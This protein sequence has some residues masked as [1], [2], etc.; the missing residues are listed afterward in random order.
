MAAHRLHE[1]LRRLRRRLLTLAAATGLGWGIACL[2][3]LLI[4]SIWLDLVAELPPPARIITS[5]VSLAAGL[6]I[7]VGILIAA[8]R[9]GGFARLARRLD[10]VG[11]ASG[12]IVAGFDLSGQQPIATSPLTAGLAQLAVDRAGEAAARVSPS[13]AAPARSAQRAWVVSASSALA[14]VLVCLT[15]PRLAGTEWLRFSD[16]FGDHPPFSRTV[17]RVEPGDTRV[18]YADGLDVLVSAEG[19]L[20]DRVDLVLVGDGGEETL[21]M[22]PESEGQWKAQL[23]E[24]VAPC[25]YYARAR[26]ARSHQYGIDVITVPRL[27]T[28]RWRIAPPAY[29]GD[30]A[31]EGPTPSGGLAGLPGTQVRVWA[32]SNRPLLAGS[33]VLDANGSQRQIE[34]APL[35]AGSREVA[36]QFTIESAGKFSLRVTDVAGQDSQEQFSGTITLLSDHRPLVRLLEP[37]EQSLATPTATLPVVVAA[38]DDYGISRLQLYRSLN[39]SRALPL[40]FEVQAVRRSRDSAETAAPRRVQQATFLPLSAYELEPGDVIK[41]YA[42]VEDNDPAGA[43]GAESAVATVQIIAADD[44]SRMLRAREGMDVFLSKYQEALRRM[45][46]LGS[47]AEGLRK[48][49]KESPEDS[50]LADEDRRRL[51]ELSQK[52][53]EAA[54]AVRESAAELLPYDL[55]KAL[56]GELERVA[57]QLERAGQEMRSAAG[58]PG[59]KAGDL[60]R[61]MREMLARLQNEKKDFKQNVTQPL[62]LFAEIYRLLEDQQRFVELYHRQRDLAER[63]A[64][65]EG[66]DGEDDPALKSR[67]RD[68]EDEQRDLRDRLERLLDEIEDRAA[69]VP[70]QPDFEDL[71]ATARDFAAAVRASDAAAEMQKGENGLA[72][73][74][75]SQA[76]V[77]AKKAADILEQFI[78]RCQG[79]GEQGENACRGLKFAPNESL[80]GDCMANT[81]A[82]LLADAGF[83]QGNGPG[84]GAGGGYSARRSALNNIGLYGNLPTR[85]NPTAARGGRRGSAPL[86]AAGS[87]GG[88]ADSME[89]GI[90]DREGAI[91]AAGA[92]SV[93]V[94]V[95]YRSRV[96]QYFQRIAEE[97][98]DQ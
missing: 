25:R 51:E 73:F 56:S 5:A 88:P 10:A 86:G 30:A 81:L 74:S 52:L 44:Y 22:F 55:D 11:G 16:P 13:A 72:E 33:L 28:V 77:G 50:P 37:A 64:S 66:R 59:A 54:A 83:K 47:E 24:I 3:G 65:L 27:E 70:D 7:G 82:Q 8:V 61:A 40:D 23:S 19:P 80:P 20:P 76:H 29:T 38:E 97:T 36:G 46:S 35:A 91:R 93:A 32:A 49:L 39:D 90:D 62:E 48:K 6:A 53:D 85:G 9:H 15:A 78:S 18:I 1:S 63:L 94:P 58:K 17:F 92:S 42:R 34:L 71:V 60:E 43:K 26:G 67:M 95:R 4:A 45:E 84:M 31:Y 69:Q 79:M 41:L 89:I 57:K 68:L 2:V 21:P 75:G 98:G 87:G 96:R 14:V 12:E